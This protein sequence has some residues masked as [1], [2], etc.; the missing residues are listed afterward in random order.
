MSRRLPAQRSLLDELPF[1]LQFA[2]AVFV[3]LLWL[4]A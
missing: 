4:L 2:A 1:A 3:L